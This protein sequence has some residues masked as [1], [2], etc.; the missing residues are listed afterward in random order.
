MQKQ[1][2]ILR[3]INVGGHRNILMKDLKD[4]CIKLGLKNPVTYIQSRN[5]VFES[6][7]KN[8]KKC[9]LKALKQLLDL[10]C[11]LLLGQLKKVIV[12]YSYFSDGVE[13]KS[14]YVT[15]LSATPSKESIEELEQIDVNDDKFVVINKEEHLYANL[16]CHKSKLSNNFFEKH[17]KVS[18]TT[19][20]WKTV[21]KLLDLAKKS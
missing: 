14:L 2:A 8:W 6:S 21:N 15:F 5:L 9:L 4:M 13:L 12:Q 19:R 16:P 7:K 1:I 10:M 3:G 20:N 11:Q 18:A 17:L